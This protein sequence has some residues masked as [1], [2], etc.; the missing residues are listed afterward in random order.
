MVG[1]SLGSLILFDLLAGQEEKSGHPEEM[2]ENVEKP[3]WDKDL[4]IEGVFSKL[5]IQEHLAVFVDQGIGIQEL[6]TCTEDDLK[7]AGLPLGPRKK[8]LMYLESRVGAASK[9]GYAEFQ[10]STVARQVSYNVGPAGTGQPSVRYPKLDVKP[11]AF[12]AL[13]SPTGCSIN[14]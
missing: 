1:H 4:S 10:A 13:G 2:D 7:E 14:H 5:E 11:T 6:K 3:S 12:F 8:L 9:T